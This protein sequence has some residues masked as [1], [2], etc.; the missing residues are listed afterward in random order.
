MF[1]DEDD[2][3]NKQPDQIVLDADLKII[4]TQMKKLNEMSK[5]CIIF[6]FDVNISNPILKRL[7]HSI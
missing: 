3:N 1:V 6:V 5:V 4:Q 7:D 2:I